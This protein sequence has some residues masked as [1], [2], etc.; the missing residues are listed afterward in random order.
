MSAGGVSVTHGVDADDLDEPES[1]PARPAFQAS[2]TDLADRC[3]LP[4]VATAATIV[5]G[6]R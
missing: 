1:L 5:G 6:Y 4:P 3:D 2:V